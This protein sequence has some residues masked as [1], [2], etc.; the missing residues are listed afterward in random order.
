MLQ[1]VSPFAAKHW[2]MKHLVYWVIYGVA[3]W[4]CNLISHPH[5]RILQVFLA[6]PFV[7]AVFY[8]GFFLADLAVRTRRIAQVV[9]W[10]IKAMVLSIGLAYLWLYV[11][12][13]KLGLTVLY[14]EAATSLRLYIQESSVVFVR[15]LL[16]GVFFFFFHSYISQ[17]RLKATVLALQLYPHDIR[18]LL[19]RWMVQLPQLDK[20][21]KKQLYADFALQDYIARIPTFRDGVVSVDVELVKLESLIEGYSDRHI[22]YRILGE[23]RGQKIV[24]LSFIV[25][26][27]NALRYS[28]KEG[29]I[30]IC[31]DMRKDISISVKNRYIYGHRPDGGAGTGLASLSERLGLLFPK[32]ASLLVKEL[33][34]YFIVELTYRTKTT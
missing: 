16:Y 30:E 32:R 25:L 4:L 12:L 11:C 21:A 27:Q 10:L 23:S 13:P 14:E 22:D 18:S 20:Q 5:T 24:P 17:N 3:C 29:L 33:D 26:F 7:M 6:L 19:S 2:Y 34:A 9:R 1:I 8:I 28:D 31:V 15:C